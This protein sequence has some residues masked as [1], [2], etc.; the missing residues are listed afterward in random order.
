MENDK[1][2]KELIEELIKVR[3]GMLTE[4]GL[5]LY[6]TIIKV[7][8]ENQKLKAKINCSK[9]NK[10]DYKDIEHCE[11]EKLGCEGCYYNK[12]SQ[13]KPK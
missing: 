4:E 9:I 13:N 6:N 12:E 3:P 7:L 11:C 1:E 8:E 5:K 10:K 2:I